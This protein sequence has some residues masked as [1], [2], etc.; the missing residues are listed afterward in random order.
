MENAG[1]SDRRALSQLRLSMSNY[2]TAKNPNGFSEWWYGDLDHADP[3]FAPKFRQ[4]FDA[5]Y[6]NALDRVLRQNAQGIILKDVE[7]SRRAHANTYGGGAGVQGL[8]DITRDQIK[9]WVDK[10]QAK[11][12]AF[13]FLIRD[14]VNVNGMQ[15]V[16]WGRRGHLRR[17]GERGQDGVRHQEDGR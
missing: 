5:L 13:G 14:T 2:R 12:L 8:T 7:G 6:D 11:G 4:R 16:A 10:A 17:Q 3:D 9:G 1:W 15:A